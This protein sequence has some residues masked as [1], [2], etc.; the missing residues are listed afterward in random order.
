[1][2]VRIIDRIGQLERKRLEMGDTRPLIWGSSNESYTAWMAYRRGGPRYG[3][4]FTRAML[5]QQ[6]P[7]AWIDGGN[8]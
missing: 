2:E 5:E 4:A 8:T 3:A 1:M 7:P 6:E